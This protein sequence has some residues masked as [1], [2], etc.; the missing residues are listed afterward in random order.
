MFVVLAASVMLAG[1]GA[2]TPA[3]ARSAASSAAS[4]PAWFDA[5]GMSKPEYEG[6]EIRSKDE[7]LRAADGVELVGTLFWRG[8]GA[9]EPQGPRP[10]ILI[11]TPYDW[12]TAAA[13]RDQ[14]EVN[15]VAFFAE[16][17]YVVAVADARG[18]GRSG[19]CADLAGPKTAADVVT[20]VDHLAGQ[21]WANGR[22]GGFGFSYSAEILKAALVLAP[23]ALRTAVVVSAGS[24]GYDYVAMD[25]VPFWDIGPYNFALSTVT[26]SVPNEQRPRLHPAKYSCTPETL[27]TV[28]FSGDMTPFLRDRD[29]RRRVKSVRASVLEVA[30]IL[31]RGPQRLA[32]DDWFDELPTFRRGVLGWWDHTS[33]KREDFMDMLHAWYDH[34]LL[35]LPTGVGQWPVLQVQG[36]DMQGRHTWRAVGSYAG[37]AARHQQYAL[38][39]DGRLGPLAAKGEMSWSEIALS[40]ADA[41]EAPTD[42]DPTAPL[43]GAVFGGV[44]FLSDPLPASVHLSGVAELAAHILIDRE[45][46]HFTIEL[47]EMHHDGSRRLVIGALSAPHRTSLEAPEPVRPGRWVRYRIRTLPFDAT[48]K[49]GSVLRLRISAGDDAFVPAGSKYKGTIRTDGSA[50]LRVPIADDSCPL[51]IGTAPAD[52][53]CPAG[54]PTGS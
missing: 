9:L 20:W 40:A 28:D 3:A 45:D 18:T 27:G 50:H 52:A 10:V 35:D 22:V 17:G 37:M 48:L 13:T 30:G 21:E 15:V 2:I 32:W 7:T 43:A 1:L 38:G 16:R 23:E 31:E 14:T 41:A 53:S 8:E 42:P 5:A 54:M 26:H 36:E 24:S 46:A 25:G 34:E 12:G 19:G 11:P 39:A 29:I 47:D 51:V 49:P 6:Q 4:A 33:P 44:V